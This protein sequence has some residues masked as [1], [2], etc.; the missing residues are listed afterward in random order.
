MNRLIEERINLLPDKTNYNF[1]NFYRVQECCFREIIYKRIIYISHGF[2]YLFIIISYFTKNG[3]VMGLLAFISY[4]IYILFLQ[5][6]YNHIYFCSKKKYNLKE[7][8]SIFFEN[9]PLVEINCTVLEGSFLKNEFLTLKP[10]CTTDISGGLIFDENE[11]LNKKVVKIRLNYEICIADV[12][13]AKQL[14]L[15]S[16]LF[17]QQHKLENNNYS[18]YINFNFLNNLQKNTLFMIPLNKT[19]NCILNFLMVIISII[20][21]ILTIGELYIYIIDKYFVETKDFTIRKLIS[22]KNR[23]N[24]KIHEDLKPYIKIGKE[25]FDYNNIILNEN[26]KMAE[27][28]SEQDQLLQNF[29]FEDCVFDINNHDDEYENKKSKNF[30]KLIFEMNKNN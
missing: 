25:V 10:Y 13:T 21:A 8:M 19:P 14:Y 6:E 3:L 9:P 27:I 20:A 12:S 2:T 1:L 16:S 29:N 24:E 5:F 15:K 30:Q 7:F 11:I 18:I 26:G 17:F 4:L 22:F 23:L 28:T